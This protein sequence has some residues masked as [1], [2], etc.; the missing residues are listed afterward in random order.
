MVN[1]QKFFE[2]PENYEG[3]TTEN[4][5]CTDVNDEKF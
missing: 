3:G 5:Y 4:V 2:D 1:V